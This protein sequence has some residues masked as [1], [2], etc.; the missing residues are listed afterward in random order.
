MYYNQ[1]KAVCGRPAR[2]ITRNSE[3]IEGSF[4]KIRKK[5]QKCIPVTFDQHIRFLARIVNCQYPSACNSTED[6][7]EFRQLITPI[8]KGYIWLLPP[9]SHI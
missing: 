6:P 4:F 2:G 9:T 8:T 7:V 5:T 3:K 1:I